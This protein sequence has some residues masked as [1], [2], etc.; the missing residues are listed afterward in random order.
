[1]SNIPTSCG[2]FLH[3]HTHICVLY[4]FQG[5]EEEEEEEEKR[6]WKPANDNDEIFRICFFLLL[7][8]CFAIACLF[9]LNLKFSIYV[10][11]RN[12][13]PPTQ[14]TPTPSLLSFI[15]S[16]RAPAPYPLSWASSF[17]LNPVGL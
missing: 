10:H 6:N 13:L 17:A 7:L 1:M 15:T 9:F 8:A 4:I 3:T 16:A 12:L 5:E 11:E 2:S 14:N